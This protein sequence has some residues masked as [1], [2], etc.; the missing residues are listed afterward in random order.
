MDWPWPSKSRVSEIEDK[1]DKLIERVEDQEGELSQVQEETK[2]LDQVVD[3]LREEVSQDESVQLQ[4]MEQEI[5]K[6]LMRAEESLSYKEIGKRMEE[7]RTA[8][9]VRPKLISLK[10]KT[11]IL[12]EKQGRKKLFRIPSTTKKEY[13]EEGEII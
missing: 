3:E 1:L 10:D 2:R 5:F 8:P 4:P 13:I 12:E 7:E 6:V 9:Q 11:T